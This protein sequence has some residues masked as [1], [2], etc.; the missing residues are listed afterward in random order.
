M[1]KIREIYRCPI[2]GNVM[3]VL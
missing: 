2:C 1:T 3:E